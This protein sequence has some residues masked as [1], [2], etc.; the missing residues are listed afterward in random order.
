MTTAIMASQA[1]A[2]HAEIAKQYDVWPGSR[3]GEF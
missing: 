3:F 1:Q 2:P